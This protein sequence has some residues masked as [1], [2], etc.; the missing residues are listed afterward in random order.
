MRAPGAARAFPSE[1]HMAISSSG[2]LLGPQYPSSAV[3]FIWATV[4]SMLTWVA[5]GAVVVLARRSS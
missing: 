1:H 2:F 4:F 3:Y 5:A